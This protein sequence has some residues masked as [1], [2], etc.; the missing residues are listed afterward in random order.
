MNAGSW[1]VFQGE[2]QAHCCGGLSRFSLGRGGSVGAGG[3]PQC[4]RGDGIRQGVVGAESSS[5]P[6][7][8]L[9]P[10]PLVTFRQREDPAPCPPAHRPPSCGPFCRMQRRV[11]FT[12]PASSSGPPGREPRGSL[13]WGRVW[14]PQGGGG[15][16]RPSVQAAGGRQAQ[17][18]SAFMNS[19]EKPSFLSPLMK[20]RARAS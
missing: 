19:R 13:H 17:L 10:T 4:S 8:H 7:P 1:V 12:L 18:G 6:L 16:P 20:P 15:D 2:E 14:W 3:T 5:L 11:R 9:P